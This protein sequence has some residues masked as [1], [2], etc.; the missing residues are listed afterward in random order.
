MTGSAVAETAAGPA[1]GSQ[2]LSRRAARWVVRL[3]W[4]WPML[5]TL[6]VGGYGLGAPSLWADELATWGA[7]RIAWRP[8]YQLLHNVDAVVGP[9]FV[10]EKAWVAIA[11]DSTVALRVPSLLAMAATAGLLALL[12]HRLGGWW[13]GLVAGGLFAFVPA[14]S[15]YGQEARPYAFSIFFA[16]LATLLLLRWL[17]RPAGDGP[18]WRSAGWGL[19]LAY[20]AAIV[21]LGAF[22]L[23]AVVLLAGHAVAALRYRRTLRWAVFAG[24]GLLP[25][26]PLAWLGYRQRGQISW[27]DK[28]AF[29]G[30]LAVPDTIF[31]A[32]IVAGVLIGL[33]ILVISGR[34]STVALFAWGVVPPVLLFL[35]GKVAHVFYPRYLLYTMPAWPVLAALA[36]ARTARWRAGVAVLLVGLLGYPTQYS[37]RTADGHN[38]APRAAAQIIAQHERTGDAIAYKLGE[39]AAW[40]ARDAVARYVPADK[41]PAD[42]FAVTPQRTD[43]KLA[44]TECA[45]LR[46]CLDRANPQRLWVLRRFTL[47]DALDNIGQAKED[48]LRPRYHLESLWQVKGLTV[49]L[50]LR[51]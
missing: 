4:L 24:L 39:S 31:A 9:Y 27:I 13:V 28:S 2:Q 45:D 51:N 8:L 48:L 3:Y 47:T 18:G 5:L 33:S 30:L 21:A 6:A 38:D 44:A 20:A 17:D 26:L 41:R 22:Q 16:V 46:A 35:A 49:A 14:V 50:Y 11:G 34:P 19:G 10:V 1:S 42:I 7:V 43:G 37:I 40:E 15:R 12:G 23:L 29:R 32:G 36:L 25:L